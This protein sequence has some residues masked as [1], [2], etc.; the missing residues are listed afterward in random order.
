MDANVVPLHT[1]D[2]VSAELQERLLDAL[3]PTGRILA[4]QSDRPT[5][6]REL[7]RVLRDLASDFEDVASGD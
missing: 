4:A 1:S 5:A 3:E 7:A 2:R 6:L